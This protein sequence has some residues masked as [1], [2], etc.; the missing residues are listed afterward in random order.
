VIDTL[1]AVLSPGTHDVIRLSSTGPLQ[2]TAFDLVLLVRV[3]QV[4]IMKHYAVAIP[5]PAPTAV[6]IV[7]PLPTIAPVAPVAS[8][9]KT[10]TKATR[11]PQR[12]R[13]YGPVG[14][15][16][17]SVARSLRANDKRR[18]SSCSGGRIRGNSRGAICMGC[19]LA[20]F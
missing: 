17:R 3:G 7:A 15:V 9:R 1:Q 10:G 20:R 12:T 2:E 14:E 11:L 19:R 18:L 6:P 16:R 5:V 13:R 4:T 8:A